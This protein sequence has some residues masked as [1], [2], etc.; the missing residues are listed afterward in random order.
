MRR[1]VIANYGGNVKA[2]IRFELAGCVQ[3]V[4][5]TL[6]GEPSGTREV[7][8]VSAARSRGFAR[9]IDRQHNARSLFPR[10]PLIGCVEEAQIERG[11]SSIVIG[12]PRLRRRGF[13]NR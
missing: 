9:G 5:I 12:D 11:V 10:R 2:W 7:G 13:G 6:R 3:K 8:V 4:T 1:S